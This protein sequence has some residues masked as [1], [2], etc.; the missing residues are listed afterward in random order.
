[1]N[2]S[3]TNDQWNQQYRIPY[4]QIEFCIFDMDGTLVNTEPFHFR[5]FL[6]VLKNSGLQL[7]TPIE[8]LEK[9]YMGWTDT[10]VIKDLFP[11]LTL[12]EI[13]TMIQHK[14]DQLLH[15]F[16]IMNATD[17]AK[18]T[19]PHLI[20]FLQLLRTKKFPLAVVSASENVVVESTLKAFHLEKYFDYWI[21]RNSTTRT[22]PFPD[23]YQLAMKV[24]GKKP[25]HTM[26]FEDSRVGLTSAFQ[27]G[28]WTVPVAPFL[29]ENHE[30]HFVKSYKDI[31]E[32]FSKN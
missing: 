28:A 11:Q 5:A 4:S 9:K 6:S 14:N 20:P 30:E 18:F 7:T 24:H 3:I 15:Q 8:T 16:S 32:K 19:A 21:G 22:K 2:F 12:A 31:A 29:T 23:P 27:S 1:M 10:S 17:R 26:I 25:G 13:S